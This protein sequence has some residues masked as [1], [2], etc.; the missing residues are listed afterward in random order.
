MSKK[1]YKIIDKTDLQVQY[2]FIASNTLGIK[3]YELINNNGGTIFYA[4]DTEDEM[5]FEQKISRRMGY[6]TLGHLYTFLK[7]IDFSD[8]NLF[9][10]HTVCEE[11]ENI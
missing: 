10:S 6:D 2:T 8:K 7:L 5:V 9:E 4:T 11:I 3:H 1:K